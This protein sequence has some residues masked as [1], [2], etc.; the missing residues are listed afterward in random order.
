M[1]MD[2]GMDTGPVLACARTAI[3]PDET[4]GHLSARL[5]AMGADLVRGELPRYVAGALVPEPQDHERATHAP[6]MERSDGSIDWARSARAV[7]DLVRGMSP[8][9]GAYTSKD[10]SRVKI[11]GAHVV[12]EHGPH[13]EPGTVVRAD[14]H[15]IE[16]ACG[17]GVVL[18]DELQLEGKRRMTAGD[19]LAGHRWD[20]GTRL[21]GG[22]R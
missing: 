10:G 22:G 18:L 4:A 5:S 15:G 20:E 2:E 8:W 11:H 16:V 13:G 21:G 6:L 7:H 12:A 19:L 1:Q 17:D 9:P 3:G 14:A